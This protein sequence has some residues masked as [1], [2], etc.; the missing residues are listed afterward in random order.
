MSLEYDSVRA[1]DVVM[2]AQHNTQNTRNHCSRSMP[3]RE[4]MGPGYQFAVF[5][6]T[7]FRDTAFRDTAFR[8]TAFRD[9]VPSGPAVCRPRRRRNN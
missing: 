4:A 5:R 8:D 7:A 2:N 6:D 9:S 1:Q 3:Y